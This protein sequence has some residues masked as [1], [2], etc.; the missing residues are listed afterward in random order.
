MRRYVIFLLLLLGV[1]RAEAQISRMRA[2]YEQ[3]VQK[4]RQEYNDFVSRANAEF[5]DFLKQS[6]SSYQSKAAEE[7]PIPDVMPT[8]P[9]APVEEQTTPRP[10]SVEPTRKPQPVPFP[11]TPA[12]R[13]APVE[14]TRKPQ[15]VPFP[16]APAPHPAPNTA[17]NP[18]P[19]PVAPAPQPVQSRPSYRG[20][21][22]EVDFFGEQLTFSCDKRTMPRLG[23]VDE[24]GFSAIWQAFGRGTESVVKEMDDYI[25]SR[26]LNGWGCYQL[27]KKFSEAVYEE[28]LSN[29]RISL[30][31]YLLSQL[32][33][34][35][36]VAL[37]G[38]V[39]VLLLPFKEQVYS[40]PY[41]E[42]EGVRYYIYGYGHNRSAGYRTYENT[43][44]YATKQLSLQ[45]DGRMKI[46]QVQ[47]VPFERFSERA[48]VEVSAPMRLGNLALMYYY[49]IVDNT[50]YY[51]QTLDEAFAEAVLSPLRGCVARMDEQ[52]AVAWLLDL[53]QHGFDYVT[54]DEA[55]GRQK[56]LFIEESFFF[57]RNNCK[58]RVGVFSWLVK[59]LV[60]LPVV[61]IRYAGN[62]AS[63]GVA[64]ITCAVAFRGDVAGDSI[65]HK[66]R[67]YVMCDP[68]YINASIGRT[69][70]CYASSRG[71]VV[72]L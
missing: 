64:H 7:A 51:A 20:V 47:Q 16:E 10:A 61:G 14:P 23:G 8:A 36:Q 13:P 9:V 71:G 32:K 5:A 50:L 24:G 2:E 60:G 57:G 70:P 33:Y 52:Q 26:Y 25:E 12:P 3:F 43:F 37:S 41:L 72:E 44:S 69:M 46:G 31:A 35:A 63:G 17:P 22:C 38:D 49:P 29:E 1:G 42:L 21:V 18:A 11:E 4:H 62:A 15:P 58:D 45:M 53:V 34:R 68:T 56:Q 55:F 48:G 39:L 54:D 59:E 67:R 28:R 66:G 6:W 19:Q 27:V 40:V 30:Q 65:T